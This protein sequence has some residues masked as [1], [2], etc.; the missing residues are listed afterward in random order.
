MRLEFIHQWKMDFDFQ[1]SKVSSRTA[2]LALDSRRLASFILLT[3]ADMTNLR[4]TEL[5]Y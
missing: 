1:L 3:I 5:S 4:L 2:S